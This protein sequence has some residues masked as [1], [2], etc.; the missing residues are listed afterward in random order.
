MFCAS[1]VFPPSVADVVKNGGDLFYYTV[2]NIPE[3]LKQI[4]QKVIKSFNVRKKYFHL[5]FF[6]LTKDVNNVG[7]VG[8]IV[9]LETNMRPAG[10]FTPDVINFSQSVSTYRI[11][12]DIIA[13]NENRQKM[14]FPKYYAACASRRDW[15]SYAHDD[16]EIISKYK[17]HLCNVG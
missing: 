15:A 9:A 5:E 17:N 10:G 4:G 3:D 12:G 13:F 2:K 7:K 1:N 11:Y 16:D 14:D 8:D 6:R